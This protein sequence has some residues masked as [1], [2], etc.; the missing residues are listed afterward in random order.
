MSNNYYNSAGSGNL[1]GV[2]GGMKATAPLLSDPV[3]AW[4]TEKQ[5]IW[6]DDAAC[7]FS[8]STMFEVAVPSDDVAAGDGVNEVHDLNETNLR[9]AQK[10]C[11]KCPV[12]SECRESADEDDFKWTMRAGVMP[13]KHVLVPVGRPA[14]VATGAKKQTTCRNGHEDWV[15]ASNG[16]RYCGPCKKA[17]QGAVNAKRP[18]TGRRTAKTIQ[19]GVECHYGHDE[20]NF[21]TSTKTYN[22]QVCRRDR[23]RLASK[24]KREAGKLSG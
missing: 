11:G 20:W 2:I 15:T 23:D 3:Y 12:I 16:K 1:A 22:C 6:Q 24:L 13:T 5:Y 7:A 14:K 10:I 19:R 8:P 18:S 17:Y 9:A 21:K 4:E